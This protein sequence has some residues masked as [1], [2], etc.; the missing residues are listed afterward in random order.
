LQD[1][2]IVI[3]NATAEI[4][5]KNYKRKDHAELFVDGKIVWWILPGNHL[6]D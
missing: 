6:I 5:N 4:I 2:S 3:K 1:R